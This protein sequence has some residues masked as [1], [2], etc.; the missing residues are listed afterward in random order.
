MLSVPH[1][2]LGF[3]VNSEEICEEI[4]HWISGYLHGIRVTV[5]D[6]AE[7]SLASQL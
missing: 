7:G 3:G 2:D 5:P 4:K 1:P 6:C